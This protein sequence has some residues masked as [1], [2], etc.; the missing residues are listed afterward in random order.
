MKWTQVLLRAALLVVLVVPGLAQA[1]SYLRV[2]S[3]N[4]RH[5]GWSGE[6]NY[7]GDAKQIWNQFGSSSTSPNGCDLVLLQEVMNSDAVAGIAN[8][9]TSVSGV[10]WSY[11]VTPLVGRSSYKE[12]YAVVYRTG[13]V[14]LLSQSLYADT[15][16]VFE[17]EPQIVRV[18]HIPTGED[19]TFINW[20]TVWGTTAE[21]EVEVRAIDTVFNSVQN[22]SGSDQ[23][24]ILA[25][26]HNAPCTSAWW[27]ELKT[28][29][30]PAVT[31]KLDVLTTINSSGG[32]ASAYDHFWLQTTYVSEFSSI[33]RDYIA[34]TLWFYNNLSD[35]APV[36]LKLYSS[37][38]TD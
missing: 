30:S 18:R 7:T 6:T 14:S 20:H 12:M 31:C 29:V 17:R 13:T 19:Y 11:A 33:G 38:D 15:N 23:D 4:L 21:R 3:W 25:G 36:W 1:G 2:V 10:T 32:Y 5:E 24:V 34:D 28:Y 35:H 16:D 9:L 26:D 22:A 37:S 27:D 8:A